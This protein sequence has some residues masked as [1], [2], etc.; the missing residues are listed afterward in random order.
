MLGAPVLAL[1][2]IGT[3][4]GVFTNTA[5]VVNILSLSYLG[6]AFPM[7]EAIT[8]ILASTALTIGLTIFYNEVLR[9]ERELI[10]LR[11]TAEQATKE[12]SE[13]V[14]KMSHEIRTPLNGVSGVLQLLNESDLTVDQRHLVNTGRASSY[15]LMSLINDV[16]DYSKISAKG[17]TVEVMAVESR[18]LLDP[19]C[20]ALETHAAAKALDLDVSCDLNLPDW[21]EVD[22]TRVTQI[23]TN[24]V[25]NAI[26]FSQIGTIALRTEKLDGF[27]RFSVSDQG[28]GL[29]Q[30]AQKRIFKKF[31]QAS[32]SITREFGGTGLGL[33]I[34]KELVELMG[35]EIGVNSVPN[36][37]STFWFTL[38]LIECATGQ[39]TASVGTVEHPRPRFDGLHIL[40]VEDN[41]T[42]QLI[43]R[44]F[45]ESM[46]IEVEIVGDGY[47]ALQVC[48]LRRFDLIFMDIQLPKLNGDDTTRA[49]RSCSGPNQ[50]TPIVALSANIF[51]EQTSTYL[52]AG[53]TAC[54]A[55]PFRKDQM[56]EVI[57]SLIPKTLLKE[58][59]A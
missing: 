18:K 14:A 17:V 22:S 26:K 40:V 30:E 37:G 24:L 15:A 23:L 4:A 41:R 7:G 45:L 1:L 33:A 10:G 46:H 42:N 8:A 35:G 12:K 5:V 31:E 49:L 20:Q 3:K 43:A 28:I 55:K 50:H 29:T 36:Q 44:R 34:C 27:V 59:A 57:R 48:A 54:L 39:Q 9:K 51:E 13:F 11:D 2:L 47:P 19:V 56:E 52:D 16:L 58:P 25:G 21:I 38:P 53:M 32:P 6:H